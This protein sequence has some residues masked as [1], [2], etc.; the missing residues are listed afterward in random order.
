V[1]NIGRFLVAPCFIFNPKHFVVGQL[2]EELLNLPVDICVFA[3][4]PLWCLLSGRYA[5]G[6]CLPACT[7]CCRRAPLRQQLR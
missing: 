4:Q 5:V 6:P 1:E 7:A 2:K 3:L